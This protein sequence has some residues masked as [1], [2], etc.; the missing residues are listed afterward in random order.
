GFALSA[1]KAYPVHRE[2]R[3]LAVADF[4]GNGALDIA[5]ANPGSALK[6]DGAVSLFLGDGRGEFKSTIHPSPSPSGGGQ[7]E[8]GLLAPQGIASAD[9]DGDGRP[10]LV[11]ANRPV[12]KNG[13]LT[14]LYND[15]AGRFSLGRSQIL[16]LGPRSKVS[17]LSFQPLVSADL[18]GDGAPD[19]AVANNDANTVSVFFNMRRPS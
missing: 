1:M 14:I 10:D 15:G 18:N 5:V 16:P 13:Q 17:T 6:E 12:R 19:I 7:K 11:V 9:F 3:S 4:D 8:E 2:A